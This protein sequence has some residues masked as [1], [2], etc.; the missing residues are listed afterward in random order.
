MNTL[1]TE[2][3]IK[4]FQ[5][6][7][8][9][10]QENFLNDEELNEWRDAVAEAVS[11]RNGLKMPG[12]MVKADDDDGNNEDP[13]YFSNVFDQLLNLWQTNDRM[14]KLMLDER[15]G[16]MAATLAGATGIRI[17][18]DQALIKRP[19]ANPTAWHLDTPFWS[20]SDRN[21]L[22]IW[23][24]LDDA[25]VE[26]GCLYFIPGSHKKTSFQNPGIT[27]NMN[28]VFEF[29]PEFAKTN[30]FCATMKA[31]T[32]SFH[33]GLCIHG[34]GANMTPGFR[35]A[36]TCAYMP[37]GAIF[38]GTQNILSEEKVSQMKVGDLLND[39]EQNPLIYT[40]GKITS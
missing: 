39:D 11:E 30:P 27:K 40:K 8:F 37:D 17:W 5:K 33:N 14:R 3:K 4:F 15:L 24:A 2:D 12:R 7:G 38:N 29:Y 13:E 28:A 16:K 21:A 31:G 6:N 34:A 32:A 20:F 25:T 10:I 18:H 1:L 19:W 23:V 35:R 9:V 36:M 22:S 26:N